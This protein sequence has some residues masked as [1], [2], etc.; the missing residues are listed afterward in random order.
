MRLSGETRHG[1]NL[2]N[3]PSG[4]L[5]IGDTLSS[6]VKFMTP[7]EIGIQYGA[8]RNIIVGAM[9]GDEDIPRYRMIE[10]GMPGLEDPPSPR[11]IRS[12]AHHDRH[13][14]L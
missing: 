8:L 10:P 5:A 2:M 4:L 9:Y 14:F 13:H 12:E 7:N 6:T 3:M 11:K 1:T